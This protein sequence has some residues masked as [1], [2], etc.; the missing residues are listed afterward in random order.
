M[1][2]KKSTRIDYV[3]D[4]ALSVFSK[5][6]YRKT[7]IEDIAKAADISR[8]G[9]YLHY[10]NKDDLFSATFLKAFNDGQHTADQVIEDDSLSLEEKLF[11]LLDEWFG[12]HVGLLHPD[13]RPHCERMIGDAVIHHNSLFQ[14]K[15]EQIIL[16]ASKEKTADKEKQAAT[17]ANVLCACALTWKHTLI[18]RQEFSDK[19]SA[20]IQ[21]CC[22]D[23]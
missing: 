13:I 9:I 23:L 7:S 12:R 1:D 3:L 15:I 2:K 20:A 11:K 6:G 18:L 14:M 21:L 22:K 17:I 4:T 5:H 8:Q 19:M 10:K 16:S